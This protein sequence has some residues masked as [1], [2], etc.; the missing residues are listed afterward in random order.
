M[1]GCSTA[2]LT[3]PQ[4][5]REVVPGVG[6]EPVPS[7]EGTPRAQVT[8]LCT[9]GFRVAS[10]DE[11]AARVAY[12]SPAPGQVVVSFA[13]TNDSLQR[14]DGVGLHRGDIVLHR[15]GEPFHHRTS[16]AARW[17][18]AAV[19]E[20]DLS[21]SSRLLLG[22]EI[23][24]PCRTTVVTPPP[25]ALSPF[26]RLHRDACRLARTRPEIAARPAV[27]VSLQHELVHAFVGC[28]ASGRPSARGALPPDRRRTMERLEEVIVARSD[29]A[30]SS[31]D[32]VAALGVAAPALRSCCRDVLGMEPTAYA[33][34]RRL[35]LAR[36]ALMGAGKAL[37]RR[38][39][40]RR[41]GF[42]E[43]RRFVTAY[44][45]AFGEPPFVRGE[46]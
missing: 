46:Q 37:G 1:I 8:W 36:S 28:L 34:L 41:F 33:R 21:A 25:D 10:L 43:P 23:A 42:A 35:A 9:R 24:L 17:A 44:R 6:L 39:I 12:V 38:A 19:T 2:T 5:Y 30:L 22:H 13:L 11:Q 16:G 45:A 31:R 3:D 27:A 14:W 18:L 4:D 26:L 40:A 15:H 20:E 29:R 32:L 7:G